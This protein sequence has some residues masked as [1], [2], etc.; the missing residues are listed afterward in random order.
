M[1]VRDKEVEAEGRRRSLEAVAALSRAMPPLRGKMN[2]ALKLMRR[3][4]RR[5]SLEGTWRLRLRD[6][7]ELDLPRRSRMAWIVA[8]TGLYEVAAVK[9]V[10]GFI[11]PQTVILDVGASL[12]L[13]TVQLG[14]IAASHDAKLWAFEPN[15]ANAPWIMRNVALNGLSE[16]VTVCEVGLGDRAESSTLV[17]AEYGVGNGWIALRDGEGTRK[18]SRVPVT[19]AR[20]DDIDLPAPVSFI[21]LD[22]EGYDAAVLRGAA[23]LIERDRPVI[24][25]EF[26]PTWLERRGENLCAALVGLD[27]DVTALARR[28]TRAWTTTDAIQPH[29][30]DLA[31]TEPLPDNLLLCPRNVPFVASRLAS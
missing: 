19:L 13:S 30:V 29:P 5:G 8:F 21:K 23:E 10:S 6:G 1:G 25:G 15:P 20:L 24:F 27:Y 14:K 26:C 18:S 16:T 17:S 3:L 9:H 12:G 22:T 7:T 4:E 11:R 31:S 2:L 28:R